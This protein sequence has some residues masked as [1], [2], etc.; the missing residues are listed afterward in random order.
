MLVA[1]PQM[2][3]WSLALL[4]I[5][6]PLL[7]ARLLLFEFRRPAF[8]VFLGVPL[9]LIASAFLFFLFL[10]SDTA[11]WLVTLAVSLSAGLYAENLFT[12]YHLPSAYQ[13]YALE[14]LSLVISVLSAFFFTSAA[15]GAHLFLRD[16]VPL[17]IPAVIV[18]VAVLF[19]TLA[20][21]WVSKVGFETSRRYA[22][23]GAFLMT[24]IFTVLT[25]LPTSFVANAAAFATLLYIYLGLMRA[26]VL[27]RLGPKVLRRYAGTALFL[28]L[29]IFGTAKWL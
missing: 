22:L 27:E 8:W 1:R 15:N 7:L 5:V 10:E 23:F 24:E 16:L 6:T 19:S 20:M 17:W 29:V 13:A 14:Y 4:F 26:H 12:F 3:W 28:L 25:F 11:K 2:V 9:F 18:F 21:F